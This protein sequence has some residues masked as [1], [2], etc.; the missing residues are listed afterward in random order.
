MIHNDFDNKLNQVVSEE[1]VPFNEENWKRMQQMLDK[2]A[3]RRLMVLPVFLKTATATAAAIAVIVS[4]YFATRPEHKNLANHTPVPSSGQDVV[5]R[6]TSTV[7]NETASALPTTQGAQSSAVRKVKKTT[8]TATSDIKKEDTPVAIDEASPNEEKHIANTSPRV[9]PEKNTKMDDQPGYFLPDEPDEQSRISLGINSGM[10]FYDAQNSFAAGLVVKGRI[11][12]RVSLQAGLGFVQTR[13]TVTTT[14][15]MVTEEHIVVFSDTSQTAGVQRTVTEST[16]EYS[17]NLPYIQF[18]PGV[19]VLVFKKLG[20]TVGADLQKAAV[21]NS[22]IDTLNKRLE[23]T[24]KKM[25]SID[26]GLTLNLNY[27]ITR[28]IGFGVS[29]RNSI[30][31]KAPGDMVYVKRNYFMLQLQYVFHPY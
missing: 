17:K 22:V 15:Y 7:V 24:G 8:I 14:Q 23:T 12:S 18:N 25:P 4:V 9:Q 2:K 19:S 29:Y 21:S 1:S 3:S 10:A 11:N 27:N 20:V 13:Q 30:L 26:A 5:L 28:N 6:D 16:E 31:N